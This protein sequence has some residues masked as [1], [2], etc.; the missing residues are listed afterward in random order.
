MKSLC[1]HFVIQFR[2]QMWVS[3]DEQRLQWRTQRGRHSDN[4]TPPSYP[5][6][7]AF[8]FVLSVAAARH[9]EQDLPGCPTNPPSSVLPAIIRKFYIQVPR[10]SS[11]AKI[12]KILTLCFSM[13]LWLLIESV[14]DRTPPK[15]TTVFN[16]SWTRSN[17][18]SLIIINWIKVFIQ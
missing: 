2:A 18:Y 16:G 13:T 8:S 10:W 14:L 11:I 5:S 1:R 15:S 6:A 7:F 9:E 4:Y 17:R 12:H 3:K